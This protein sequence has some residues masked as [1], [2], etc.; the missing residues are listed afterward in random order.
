MIYDEPRF[1]PGGDT[2]VLVQ[3]G[4]E[5]RIDLN[6]MA[7]G[8]TAA[9]RED[10]TKGVIDTNP[11]YNS[12]VVEYNP[13]LIGA[14]DLEREL[15]RLIEGLGSVEELELESR[16]AYLPVM[17]NDPWTRACVEDYAQ[18]IAARDGD[19]EFVARIN[20]L[21]DSAQLARV[22]SGTEHW[23]VAVCSTPG[24][25]LMV[26]LDPRCAITSPKYNPP[27]TWTTLGAI[28]V[29]G[30]STSIYTTPGPGGYNLIGRTPVPLWDT[31][32]RLPVY[33]DRVVLLDAADRVKFVP[34]E[35]EEFEY[36]E[37]RVADGTYAFNVTGY[38]RFS[39]RHYKAWAT[40]LDASERF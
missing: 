25:P 2:F 14:D 10:C 9:L 19:P 30:L 18:R 33:R 40:S 37:R 7:L 6:F 29:G 11:S 5:A 17:Y 38:Q 39:V 8:L 36:I 20:G 22:H 35:L 4:D 16:L 21:E 12:V 32:A 24:L 26:A 28:G 15:R 3:F 34:V 23:V 27:R 13:D 1:L 31:Q